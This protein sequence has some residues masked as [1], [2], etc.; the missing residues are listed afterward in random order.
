M[1]KPMFRSTVL[2]PAASAVVSQNRP[3][4]F[5]SQQPAQVAAKQAFP[6]VSDQIA[7]QL[8]PQIQQQLE[9]FGFPNSG[10]VVIGRIPGGNTI[11]L[12]D[13]GIK[14]NNPQPGAKKVKNVLNVTLG[15]M[16]QDQQGNV[17]FAVPNREAILAQMEHSQ[18]M[19]LTH[20][21]LIKYYQ[22]ALQFSSTS[23]IDPEHAAL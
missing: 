12:T 14:K 4:S 22:H 8:Y 9:G 17:D 1:N 2:A 7:E 16:K 21:A 20:T 19:I 5:L 6:P 23:A 3:T 11:T 10:K 13:F 15:W 18:R